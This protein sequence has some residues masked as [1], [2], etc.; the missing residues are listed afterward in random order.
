LV[1]QTAKHVLSSRVNRTPTNGTLS[2]ASPEAAGL[3]YYGSP[4]LTT[5]LTM[6]LLNA[7]SQIY[8]KYTYP[9]II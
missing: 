6:S 8:K 4:Y 7:W 3:G 5:L 9:L 1:V 2:A